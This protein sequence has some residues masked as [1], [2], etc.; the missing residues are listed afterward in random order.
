M[1]SSY[2]A[3]LTCQ[4]LRMQVGQGAGLLGA[5]LCPHIVRRLGLRRGAAMAQRLQ[6]I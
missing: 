6:V 1:A 2:Y 3:A 5:L 4:W